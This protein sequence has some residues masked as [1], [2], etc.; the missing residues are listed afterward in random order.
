M[1]GVCLYGRSSPAHILA[2]FACRGL[3]NELP[4]SDFGPPPSKAVIGN[5]VYVCRLLYSTSEGLL[6]LYP[7]DLHS[8]IS[9]AWMEVGTNIHGGGYAYTLREVGTNIHGGGYTYTW[10]EVGTNIHG[11]GYTYTWREVGINIHGGGYA[12]TLREV[13]TNIHGGG[14]LIHRGR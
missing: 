1:C 12:Y 2:E 5:F 8:C 11:A 4:S 9:Q 7:Y 13:G 3:A 10:R 14:T 6:V